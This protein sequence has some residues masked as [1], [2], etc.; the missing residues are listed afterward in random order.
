M[1]WQQGM[2]QN[3]SYFHSKVREKQARNMINRLCDDQGREVEDIEQISELFIKFYS[4]LPGS[5]NENLQPIDMNVLRRG[6]VLNDQQINTLCADISDQE[7][8]D[9]LFSIDS[10]K[11]PGPDGFGAGFFKS[12]WNIV[13]EDITAAVKGFFRSGKILKQVN[14]TILTLVPKT[15]CP[16]SVSDFRPIA[17]CN[18]VY[19]ITLRSFPLD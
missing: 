18:T 19:K 5:L 11:A 16:N 10:E 15:D 14:N 7:I 3:T 17:C 9:A 4:D 12:S 13:K 1:E 2:N 8:H 6:P